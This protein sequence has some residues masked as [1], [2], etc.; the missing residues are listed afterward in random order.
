M[1]IFELFSAL[2]LMDD[3]S[4]ASDPAKFF[5]NLVAYFCRLVGLEDF[6]AFVIFLNQIPKQRFLFRNVLIL[7]FVFVLKLIASFSFAFLIQY[8]LLFAYAM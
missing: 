5:N 3:A 2:P 6:E 7:I 8:I 1:R 4:V